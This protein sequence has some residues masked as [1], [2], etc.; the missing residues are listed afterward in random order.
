M[1]EPPP[2][3]AARSL[4][5]GNPEGR[6]GLQRRI[7]ENGNIKIAVG[8]VSVEGVTAVEPRAEEPAVGKRHREFMLE[9]CRKAIEGDHSGRRFYRTERC[10]PEVWTTDAKRMEHAGVPAESG[11]R[12]KRR[13]ALEMP[14]HSGEAPVARH[15]PNGVGEADGPAGR[16]APARVPSLRRRHPSQR[17]L[18]AE[19]ASLEGEVRKRAKARMAS[20]A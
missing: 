17:R 12:P 18:P 9:N 3:P 6:H 8:T 5:T 10:L 15:L 20:F 13:L 16:G 1:G 11:S 4:A 14:R 2:E 7:E 19:P